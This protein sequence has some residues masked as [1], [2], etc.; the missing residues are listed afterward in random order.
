MHRPF[1]PPR[2]S[3]K[4]ERGADTGA[5]RL[6]VGFDVSMIACE[7]YSRVGHIRF[8]VLSIP[9]QT[10]EVGTLKNRFILVTMLVILVVASAM[11][12]TSC[13]ASTHVVNATVY[14][15][16]SEKLSEASIAAD[17]ALAELT[18][19][20][21][22]AAPATIENGKLLVASDGAYPPL[23]YFARVVTMEG[24]KETRSDPQLVGFEIDLCKAVAKKLGLEPQFITYEFSDIES[25]LAEGKEVDM[26]ASGMITSAG[27]L[28]QL[29]ASDTYLS[30]DL[31][32]CTRTGIDL[33]DSAALQ[34]KVVGVQTGSTAES[35]VQSIAGVAEIRTYPHV[36]GAFEDLD[37]SE[38]DAVVVVSHVARWILATH[39]DYANALKISGTLDADEGFAFWCAK[40]DQALVA[41]I[42][43]ALSELRQA[44]GAPPETS[45][46]ADATTTTV[47]G[48]EIT[49]PEA[50]TTTENSVE[51]AK[52]VY[53][54]LLEKWGLTEN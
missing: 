19:S 5:T 10:R 23:Q 8:S 20:P 51:P 1:P 33:A 53:Q 2:S 11:T 38:V 16:G 6:V 46:T 50:T 28:T 32:I 40:E 22:I 24:D 47:Q 49:V 35:T 7:V 30:A 17:L 42:N 3:Q 15:T 29:S 12:L 34:G 9:V 36:L 37:A 27:L 13:A 48:T 52:S 54:L 41:A 18:K 25:V 21:D 31:A 14:G 26:A 43:A 4:A 44:P 39:A 45:T